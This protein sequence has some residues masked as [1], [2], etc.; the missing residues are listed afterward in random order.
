MTRPSRNS[1]TAASEATAVAAS[2]DT[3]AVTEAT[4]TAVI[5]EQLSLSISCVC[6]T[7]PL[8]FYF[9]EALFCLEMKSI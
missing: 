8:F 9:R 5:E 1:V 7:T 4:D 2:V 3:A 6:R